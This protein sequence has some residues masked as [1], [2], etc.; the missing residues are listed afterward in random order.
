MRSWWT[1]RQTTGIS[2]ESDRR[3]SRLIPALDNYSV[4]VVIGIE[5]WPLKQHE[6]HF[7]CPSYHPH[8]YFRRLYH[9][10]I[11]RLRTES[12]PH[13]VQIQKTHNGRCYYSCA[14]WDGVWT[15]VVIVMKGMKCL[16]ILWFDD[17]SWGVVVYLKSSPGTTMH[18]ICS[19][20]MLSLRF[21][22]E[23]RTWG[24]SLN[25]Y[26]VDDI[27]NFLIEFTF[28]CHDTLSKTLVKHYTHAH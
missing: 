17:F 3:P 25:V 23:L 19:S 15:A 27:L 20:S 11:I 7:N 18:S 28:L 2:S 24:W 13:L 10:H 8:E 21:T 14:G 26:V 1:A 12:I 6:T 22:R 5:K 4:C 16:H 9:K